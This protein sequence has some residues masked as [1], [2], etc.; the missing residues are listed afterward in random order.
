M[1]PHFASAYSLA[2]FL[3]GDRTTAEDLAQEA[4]LK[5]FAAFESYRGGSPRAWLLAIVRHAFVDWTR[6]NRAWRGALTHDLDPDQL[7]RLPDEGAPD[8][9]AALVARGDAA[10]LRAAIDALAEPFREAVVMRDLEGL[11]YRQIA[12]ATGAPIGTVMSRLA[13]GRRD[14][15]SRLRPSEAGAPA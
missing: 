11:S 5:A 4:L 8:P 1:Q 9:E 14:L 13:R 12:E 15:L 7:A 3:C 6:R 10:A 2:R